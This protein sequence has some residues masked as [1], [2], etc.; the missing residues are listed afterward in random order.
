MI[1]KKT[2]KQVRPKRL[3]R[4]RAVIRG[5]TDRPRVAILKSNKALYGSVHDDAAGKTLFSVCIKGKTIAH[6]KELG[7]AL[8]EKAK[9]KKISAL[10]FDRGGYKYHG[11]VKA[12]AEGLREGGI[13]V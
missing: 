7:A 2:I 12:I 1:T 4:I 10:V 6:G 9:E 8:S 5:T 3:A 11:V 13:T